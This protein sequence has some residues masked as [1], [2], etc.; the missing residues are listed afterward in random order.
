MSNYRIISLLFAALCF[1]TG[2]PFLCYA[3]AI[4]LF[5]AMF[6]LLP[7]VPMDGGRLAQYMLETVMSR[8]TAAIILRVTGSLCAVGVAATGVYI[9]SIT[10]AA[11]GIWMGTLANFP[12]LR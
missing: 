11:V 10:M 4:A 2:I 8:R 9:R 5:A 12:D 3:G 7:V 6:N 1:L